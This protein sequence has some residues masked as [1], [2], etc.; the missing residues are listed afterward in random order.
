AGAARP[1]QKWRLCKAALTRILLVGRRLSTAWTAFRETPSRPDAPEKAEFW[2]LM[3]GN[4]WPYRHPT[5]AGESRH[6][7]ASPTS[8]TTSRAAALL[9]RTVWFRVASGLLT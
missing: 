5:L 1:K 4:M 8:D 9:L 2:G 3:H 6:I 7:V